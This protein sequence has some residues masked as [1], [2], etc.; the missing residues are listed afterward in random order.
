MRTRAITGFFF[1]IVLVASVVTGSIPFSVFFLIVSLGCLHE[2]YSMV[3]TDEIKPNYLAG[4]IFSAI[5]FSLLIL[6]ELKKVPAK[7]FLYILPFLTI[8]FLLELYRKLEKP[9]INIA[10]TCFGFIFAV[11]PFMFFYGLGFLDGPYSYQYP[12]G[13]LIMLWAS[14]TGAY[15]SGVTFGKHK[16]F[17]RHSPKKTWEGFGG[18]LVISLVAAFIISRFYHGLAP[19]QWFVSSVIIVTFGTYGDL[20]ESMLKRSHNTKDSGNI[21]PGH[22]GLLDRFD[23]LLLAAPLVYVFLA[24]SS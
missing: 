9:F 11:L 1:V 19:W 12:L 24:L 23:G 18:G 13:F 20:V 21:L 10:Y 8:I 5:L 3:K 7:A 22:G 6:F 17:E 16:L 14:D 2:F 4:L 15:I